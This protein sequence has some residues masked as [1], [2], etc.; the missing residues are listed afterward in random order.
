ML[1]SEFC[2]ILLISGCRLLAKHLLLLRCFFGMLDSC[3]PSRQRLLSCMHYLHLNHKAILI[4]VHRALSPF[5]PSCGASVPLLFVHHMLPAGKG[6]S[7]G[8]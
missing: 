8:E 7:L 4:S 6:G 1:S 5:P 2:L 3:S